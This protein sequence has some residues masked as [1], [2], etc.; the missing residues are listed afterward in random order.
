MSIVI[1]AGLAIIGREFACSPCAPLVHTAVCSVQC[2]VSERA[3]ALRQAPRSTSTGLSLSSRCARRPHGALWSRQ[4]HAAVRIS[5]II[6]IGVLLTDALLQSHTYTSQSLHMGAAIAIAVMI[7]LFGCGP[8]VCE[9]PA[10]R[11]TREAFAF[12]HA[13]RLRQTLRV[14][15]CNTVAFATAH[16]AFPCRRDA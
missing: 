14:G 15:T 13:P 3:A 8:C 2:S 12:A 1:G 7:P 5:Q 10:R 4:S 11:G 6:S 16:S 9:W